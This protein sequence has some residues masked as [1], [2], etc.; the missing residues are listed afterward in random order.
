MYLGLCLFVCLCVCVSVSISFSVSVSVPVSVCLCL[1]LCVCLWEK[2]PRGV[3]AHKLRFRFLVVSIITLGKTRIVAVQCLFHVACGVLR[4]CCVMMA[5]VSHACWLCSLFCAT[6][7]SRICLDRYRCV[8]VT[9]ARPFAVCAH[10]PCV[11]GTAKRATGMRARPQARGG[12]A[13]GS[14][15]PLA[16]GCRKRCRACSDHRC[17]AIK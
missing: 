17:L 8:L 15:W 9:F 7:M 11:W 13:E 6:M 5:I 10:A 2:S 1:C 14:S 12:R 4:T 3:S 16:C